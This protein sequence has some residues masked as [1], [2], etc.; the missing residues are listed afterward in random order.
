[1]RTNMLAGR[2]PSPLRLF[3]IVAAVATAAGCT[4]GGSGSQ[5]GAASDAQRVG[6]Q[7]T[8]A[9]GAPDTGASQQL[10]P[11]R[12]GPLS[13]TD[14]KLLDIVE[15]TSIREIITSKWALQR[16]TNP[17]IK[18]AARVIISQHVVLERQ[19]KAVAKKL[20][21]KLPNKPAP[22]MQVGIDRMSHEK[23]KTFDKDYADTLRQAHGQALIL[24]S[25]VRADTRNT[26][27]RPFAEFAANFIMTHMR[28]LE[29]SGDV[30]FSKLPIPQA[31]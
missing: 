12:F 8:P 16:S 26:L 18:Q 25:T 15:Q 9:A 29:Q 28:K 5:Q 3:C 13:A 27:V 1:M 30:H 17:R 24:L 20:G 14:T 10:T 2:T 6:N 23:G 31:P 22:D 19:D 7:S 21:L 11:T 4:Y